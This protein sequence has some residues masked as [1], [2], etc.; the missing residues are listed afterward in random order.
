[1]FE[2]HW[3]CPALDEWLPPR[4]QGQRVAATYCVPPGGSAGGWTPPRGVRRLVLRDEVATLPD[5]AEPASVDVLLVASGL[6][7]PLDGL[8]ASCL[9]AV[10]PGGLV[11]DLAAVR[12][13]A[14]GE[15]FRPWVRGARLRA[16][17]AD[18]V[19]QWL[20]RGAYEPEQW[21]P[22]APRGV[23]LTMVRRGVRLY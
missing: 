6:P 15:M 8:R 16:A 1:M 23:L 18:R 13:R 14:L 2:D 9:E 10:R 20:D 21:V 11:I 22:V 17:A 4:W 7:G 5:P 3:P 12:S 19:R